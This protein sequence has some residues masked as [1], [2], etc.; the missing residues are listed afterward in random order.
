[1]PAESSEL[2]PTHRDR[3]SDLPARI[4][5][6]AL[7]DFVVRQRWFGGKA[8]GVRDVGLDD[9]IPLTDHSGLSVVRVSFDEGP[10]DLYV[11]PLAHVGAVPDAVAS[12]A[13]CVQRTAD[14]AVI[15]ALFDDAFCH[16]WLR[17]MQ[18]GGTRS[19]REGRL[20]A[21]PIAGAA[22]SSEA[23]VLRRTAPDQSNTSV[24]VGSRL[25]LKVFRRL[26]PGLNPDVEIGRFLT[27][28]GF[29]YAPATRGALEYVRGT[30]APASVAVL[31]SF[32]PNRGNGWQVVL[33]DL[34][35]LL[36]EVT[37][38][39]E[40]LEHRIEQHLALARQL[41]ARTGAMHVA[42]AAGDTVALAAEAH[43]PDVLDAMATAMRERAASHLAALASALPRLDPHIRDQA[44]HLL[45]QQ[46]ALLGVFAA[47]ASVRD[48]G[49]RVRCHGD[50]HLGQTLVTNN[51]E[52][53]V[54]DFEGEPARS[55]AERR[56]K[57]SPLRD[58]AGMLRSFS[59]AAESALRAAG[60]QGSRSRAAEDAV[61]S[62]QQGAEQA[63]LAAYDEAVSN[64]PLLPGQAD[65]R[66]LLLKAFT[67]DKAAYELVYELNNRPDW[68]GIPLAGLERLLG[69]SLPGTAGPR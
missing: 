31:Q 3:H 24:I 30:D 61:H 50:Y 28:R 5:P 47:V 10:A 66:G 25:I 12:D 1:M 27:R 7:G 63:F 65:A 18:D 64:T 44:G 43:T 62:W 57:W 26:T 29:A 35:R 68:I 17:L 41:G 23:E 4:D 11:L 46:E 67:I 32:V 69:R 9:W 8:R 6:A 42:L 16:A 54:L 52:V 20:Q 59:Y 21:E 34:A 48:A 51:D 39:P 60:L 14:G 15:D 38:E 58:V 45:A 55:L 49:L 19:G 13:V 36:D 40:A 37:R 2:H 33:G 22:P 53:V 56:E